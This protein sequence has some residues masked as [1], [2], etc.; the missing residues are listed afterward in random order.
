MYKSCTAAHLIPAVVPMLSVVGAFHVH[1]TYFGASGTD[2]RVCSCSRL[3]LGVRGNLI[4]ICLFPTNL[5]CH[6]F[7]GMMKLVKFDENLV[8]SAAWR[9]MKKLLYFLWNWKEE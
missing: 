2:E 9:K 8:V 3:S 4:T 5:T 1:T 6:V 7:L